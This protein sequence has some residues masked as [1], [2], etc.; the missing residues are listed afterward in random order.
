[1][2]RINK[3]L[4]LL[5]SAL[6][7]KIQRQSS[8]MNGS[9]TVYMEQMY[10]NWLKD[11]T[12]V[13]ASW[14]AYFTNLNMNLSH[15][16]SFVSPEQAIH[17]NIYPTGNLSTGY[18]TKKSN[19]RLQDLVEFFR[20]N[21]HQIANLDPLHMDINKFKVTIPLKEFELDHFF[22]ESEFDIEISSQGLDDPLISSQ[23]TW[24]PR[25]LFAL[26]KNIYCNEMSCLFS[27]MTD[28]KA[29]EWVRR[30]FE[31]NDEN[32]LS[33]EEH[34]DLLKT[35]LE[36][37]AFSNYS[38]V[39][40]ST[41][42][43]F[44]SDGLDTSVSAVKE[45]IRRF[46]EIKGSHAIIG[47]AH[48]GRLNILATVL[49]KPY[50]KMFM[51]YLNKTPDFLQETVYDF[52]GDVKYH[53]DYHNTDTDKHGNEIKIE[54]LPN[55]SHL[56]AVNT[57]V[58]GYVKG[59][60]IEMPVED[61]YKILP[62]IIHGDAALAGQGVIYEALQMELLDN[63][64]VEGSIHLVFNNQI[65]F[66]TEPTD[67]R[68]NRY[69]TTVAKTNENPI[70][71]VNADNP[72]QVRKAVRM[73]VDYRT[74][75]KKDIF[76]D[77]IGYRKHG[78]NEQDNPRFTQP[79]MYK[80][81]DQ[82]KPMYQKYTAWLVSQGILT[83]D[84]IDERYRK[85]YDDVIG[86]GYEKAKKDLYNPNIWS[87]E[88]NEFP[89]KGT[90]TSG[91]SSEFIRDIGKTVYKIDHYTMNLDNTV[92]KIYKNS[93]KAINSGIGIDWATAEGL[94][95]G[96]LLK[97]GYL[98]RLSGE[99]VERGTFS[100]RHSV[101]VDQDDNSK[102]FPLHNL[103]SECQKGRLSISNSLLSEYGVLGFDY[104]FSWSRPDALT[105]W[106]AQFGDF[107][108]GAQIIIDQFLM[109]SEKKWRRFSNL[110]MLLPHGYD[111]MGPEHS[112]ARIERFI[113]NVDDNFIKA[114]VDQDYRDNILEYCNIQ[115]CNITTPANYFHALRNQLKKSYRKPLVVMSPKKILRHKDVKS[116]M[117]DLETNSYFK[118]I[119]NDQAPNSPKNI[120]Q[121]VL[122]CS[123]QIYFEL[124]NR[125]KEL[126]KED[127]LPI[128]RLE[129]LA[130]FPYNEFKES[131][132]GYNKDVE[133]VFISE[134]QL[135]FGAFMN[136][137]PRINMML[138]EDGFT[139]ELQYVGRK[140][141][142]SSSTG[143]SS[144][145]LKEIEEILTNSVGAL[146]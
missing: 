71:M 65:G 101:L 81:I 46:H 36:S 120:V 67:G 49:K 75:F 84:E 98:V 19:R 107:A 82:M 57:V 7:T 135:N 16:Q 43:R 20:I 86:A 130:P 89:I 40:F 26:M 53:N 105:I 8:F 18:V 33:K 70:I 131:I 122:I 87:L 146:V 140:V 68:S 37:Q 137:N 38:N 10:M 11:N 83:Q 124:V 17:S 88:S 29:R 23:T 24:K 80:L 126:G 58:Q 56:E 95:F 109:N 92:K 78:H 93:L 128:I 103:L 99:D 77:I 13:H 30:R 60:Q 114:K 61:Q 115:V 91:L 50:E 72:V 96:S 31:A 94:A 113:A 35:I 25:E 142:S 110:V 79:V 100:H 5:R 48:R 15:D 34:I 21:G 4:G 111:G 125:R 47:M 39:K 144:I 141:S 118:P 51:E 138:K 136:V 52:Y 90:T 69:C 119:I 133:F 32:Y 127:V 9:N 28:T 139:C 102:V 85:Y 104:G 143:I 117:V 54:M 22:D 112:N 41:I 123:G 6:T 97:E 44:G 62:I 59:L 1:M 132:Q 106:E 116:D 12:S 121:K 42:K 27:H 55:P 134:E 2:L 64:E 129:R 63:F 45:I 145:H 76:I 66:T 108:N 74:E 3:T 73:A 14:N